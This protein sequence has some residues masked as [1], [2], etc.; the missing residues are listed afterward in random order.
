MGGNRR[1]L[2]ADVAKKARIL[3]LQAMVAPDVGNM[4]VKQSLM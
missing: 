3:L 2:P 4:G 1:E